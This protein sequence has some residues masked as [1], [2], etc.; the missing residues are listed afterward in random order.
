MLKYLDTKVVFAEIPDEI[1]LAI[2]ISGCPCRCPDCHSKYLWEDTGNPLTKKAV[3]KLV[4]DNPGITCVAFMGGD[5]DP[6]ELAGIIK[7]LSYEEFSS[8]SIPKIA[9]YSGREEIEYP[10]ILD[11]L[12]FIKL[13]PF[14]KEFGPLNSP[15]TNQ[16][17]YKVEHPDGTPKLTDI[18]SVFWEKAN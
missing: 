13:G 1:T 5:S 4:E 9:W 7:Y 14:I 15:T 8:V 18:T 12:D 6:K 16:K 17:F 11:D 3:K 2:N 10:Q